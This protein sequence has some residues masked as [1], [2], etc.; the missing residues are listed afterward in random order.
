MKTTNLQ[1]HMHHALQMT[2]RVAPARTTMP[3]IQNTLMRA[4]DGAVELTATNLEMTLRMRIPAETE[5]EGSLAVPNKL[6]SELISTLPKGT[7]EMERPG[8][9]MVLRLRCGDTKA[10]ING[11]DANLFPPVP[12]VDESNTVI[13]EADEFRKAVVRVAHCAATET[14]RPALTGVLMDL[15]EDNLT[16]AGADGFRLAVQ[17]TKLTGPASRPARAVVPAKTLVEVQRIASNVGGQVEILIPEDGKTIRFRIG[18]EGENNSDIEVT[19]LLLAGTYPAYQALVPQDMPNQAVFNL[20]ELSNAT[21]RAE[22]FARDVQHAVQFE[23]SRASGERGRALITS[24]S[25][26]VGDN[27]AELETEMVRGSAVS[28]TLNGRYIHEALASL[29]SKQV[30]LETASGSSPA[31]I[32]A[33]EEGE[34]YIHVMM[35]IMTLGEQ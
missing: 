17:R 34:D 22:I 35:P 23:M 26:E 13:M 21:R 16:T 29:N 31:K 33:P 6:L 24:K 1:E 11:A 5:R 19:S 12:E 18:A 28:I 14:S 15:D 2:S 8:E 9:T 7:V 30:S 25:N 3:I 27:R 10:N 32:T 4:V 20:G